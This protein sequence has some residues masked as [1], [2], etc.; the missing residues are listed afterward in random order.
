MSLKTIDVMWT[1]SLPKD[2]LFKDYN[3]NDQ[4][5]YMKLSFCVTGF[6]CSYIDPQ[7]NAD[8]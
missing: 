6:I 2:G 4:L 7:K 5:I 8:T 1:F 3:K